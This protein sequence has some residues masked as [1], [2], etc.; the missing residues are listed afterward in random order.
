MIPLISIF[1]YRMSSRWVADL[2]FLLSA[3]QRTQD[4]IFGKLPV[5][6]R[7]LRVLFLSSLSFAPSPPGSRSRLAPS[8]ASPAAKR[9]SSCRSFVTAAS[10]CFGESLRVPRQKVPAFVGK[11]SAASHKAKTERLLPVRPQGRVH[12]AGAREPRQA[13]VGVRHSTVMQEALGVY[14]HRQR[15][16]AYSAQ[17]STSLSGGPILIPNPESRVF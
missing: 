2:L 17:N 15:N 11:P 14:A 3:S 6:L 4:R 7:N 8:Q 1:E 10:G 9:R 12:G 5:P 16:G 13:V